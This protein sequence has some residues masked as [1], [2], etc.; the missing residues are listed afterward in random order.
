MERLSR[1]FIIS[2]VLIVMS[3]ILVGMDGLWLANA[4]GETFFE[5]GWEDGQEPGLPNQVLYSNDVANPRCSRQALQDSHNGG[6][7]LMVT[8]ES[9]AA[10][11]Y[12]YHKVFDLN[13][14]V[15]NG[16]KIG[17]W[18]YHVEG[19]GKI[20]VDGQ[21]TDGN[22]LRD[23]GGQLLKDQNGIPIHPA[24]R[25]DP[26][27]EWVYVEV[28]LSA[29]AGKTLDYIMFAFDNGNDGFKGQYLAYVDDFKIFEASSTPPSP[30]SPAG[31]TV[32]PDCIA[33]TI[34]AGNWKAEYY[35][36]KTLAGCRGIVSDE[37]TADSINYDWGS[38]GPN[39]CGVGSDNFSVR[40]T[41][42][43]HF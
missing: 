35:P 36:N 33:T 43:V 42:T 25:Q 2:F 17:Y 8:G 10:Y 32:N 6:Y 13:I 15:V 18:I 21:F 3:I 30:V 22:T 39:T 7:G 31:C 14:P 5:S 19:T 11:A 40:W 29:A 38:G 20:A 27:D 26:M 28:D 1:V 37:G 34:P 12:S 4:R 9:R 41:R 24:H 16:M 23:F